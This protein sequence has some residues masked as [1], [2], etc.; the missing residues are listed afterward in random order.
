MEESFAEISLIIRGG[1]D[2][3]FY[4]ENYIDVYFRILFTFVSRI[5]III[6]FVFERE[7]R[8]FL[9]EVGMYLFLF[10]YGG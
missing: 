3:I 4:N 10:T 6:I 5:S 1:N 2:F 9:I 8:L 7:Y